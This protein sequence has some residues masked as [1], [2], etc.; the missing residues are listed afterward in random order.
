[1]NVYIAWD[2]YAKYFYL[3]DEEGYRIPDTET[4]LTYAA[5]AWYCRDRGF[6]VLDIPSENASN[7]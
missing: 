3:M 1:M 4:F 6:T 5:A 7:D 2:E